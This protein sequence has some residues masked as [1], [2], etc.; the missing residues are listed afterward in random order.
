MN[1]R[2]WIA[3]LL[4]FAWSVFARAE[5]VCVKYGPCPLD[6]GPFACTD[7]PQSSFVRR[8]CYHA[9]KRFMVIK[10]KDTWYP[11]CSVDADSV[12]ALIS[13]PSVGRHYNARFRSH[14]AQH[15]S[16]DCRDHSVPQYP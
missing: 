14:G 5:T 2:V 12:K 8:I 1:S 13:A 3:L 4:A 7:T 15:G 10:L 11:Y 6:L 9:T 16:F